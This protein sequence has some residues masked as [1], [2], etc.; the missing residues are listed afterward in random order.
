MAPWFDCGFRGAAVLLLCTYNSR[1]PPPPLLTLVCV[2]KVASRKPPSDGVASFALVGSY[3]L[4][5]NTPDIRSRT[6][7]DDHTYFDI[8]PLIELIEVPL[9]LSPADYPSSISA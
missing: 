3:T 8:I 5:R 1:A 2:P 4:V 9:S 7:M 6:L